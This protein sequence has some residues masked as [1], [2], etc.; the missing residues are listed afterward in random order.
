M[1]SNT[2]PNQDKL[3]CPLGHE[4]DRCILYRCMPIDVEDP[5]TGKKIPAGT[6]WDCAWV[7]NMI[8]AW[9]AGRQTQGVHAA[10]AQQTAVQRE[11][12]ERFLSL[13]SGHRPEALPDAA[14]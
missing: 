13:A 3:S 4:C 11:Q 8:G 5:V 6:V 10:V 2:L 14:G 9:D 1:L 7:W 12:S